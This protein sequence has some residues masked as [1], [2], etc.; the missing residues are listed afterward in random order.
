MAPNPKWN[1]T[2]STKTQDDFERFCDFFFCLFFMFLRSTLKKLVSFLYINV[3]E[4]FPY[5]KSLQPFLQTRAFDHFWALLLIANEV[6][7][8]R[9]LLVSILKAE[10]L[11]LSLIDVKVIY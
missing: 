2:Q 11:L 4:F 5:M 8:S 7:S 6:E 9:S 3:Q 10:S 1:W